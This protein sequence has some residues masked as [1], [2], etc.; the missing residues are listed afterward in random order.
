LKPHPFED[1]AFFFKLILNLFRLF[2]LQSVLNGLKSI[3]ED[4]PLD[5]G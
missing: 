1:G 5:C 4:E 3:E 2:L